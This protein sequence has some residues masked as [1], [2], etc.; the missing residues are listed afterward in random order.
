MATLLSFLFLLPAGPE[1][2]VVPPAPF[3]AARFREHV[4]YLASD[5][6]A[7]RDV[8]SA[9]NAKAVDYLVR[10]LK[11]CGAHGLAPGDE[12]VQAFP[13]ATVVKASMKTTLTA[14]GAPLRLGEDFAPAPQSPNGPWEGEM[15]FVGYAISAPDHGY[16]D[17]AGVDLKGKIAVALAETSKPLGAAGLYAHGQ[18]DRKW[19]ECESRGA[20]A[21]IVLSRPRSESGVLGAA[22]V[23][24]IPCLTVSRATMAR[25]LR[26]KEGDADPVAAAEEALAPVGKPKPGSRPLNRKV[27]GVVQLER[28]VTSGR[29]LIAVVPG[30]GELA[31]EAIVVSA[32]HDHLGTDPELIK[33]GKDGIY[34]GADD[35]ASGC[36]AMLLLAEALHSDRERLPASRRSVIFASFDA[37]ERGLM[38]SRYYVGHPLWPLERTTANLNFDMVGRLNKSKLGAMDSLSNPFLAERITALAAECGLGVETRLGGARRADNANFLDREIPAVHFN[39]GLHADYHQVTDEVSRID[40][41]GGARISWLAYRLLRETMARPGRLRYTAPPPQFDAERLIRLVFR[42][43]IVPELNT[44]KGQ[45]PLI[46]SVL[47]GSIAARNG[48][49]GGDE[50]TSINGTRIEGLQQA[51]IAF[52]QVRLQ[53]GLRVSVRRDGKTVDL[54][55]PAEAFKGFTGPEVR[56]LGGDQFEV[57]FRFQP[58]AKAASV[59]LAGTFND[60]SLK[61]QPMEGPD[62]QGFYTTKLRLKRG[63]YEYKFVVDGKT[64]VADP[65]NFS[66]IGTYGNSLLTLG[67][68]P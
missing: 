52:A 26:Q 65:S 28:T 7:G 18:L 21:L 45:Y 68:R 54:T 64:W 49:K 23:R 31:R 13:F 15:V 1:S 46:R 3:T 33:A 20:R 57:S 4:A 35:N 16:D 24:K 51:G 32:H 41:E 39:T 40:A 67:D 60:W 43:G 19:I 42:L 66:T 30:K 9:G 22:S 58:P 59:V 55:V 38:G 6:L 27:Q 62:K 12:W 29:N 10:H 63:S 37:E 25:L 47:P 56:P 8:A 34:N 2:T 14:D 48:L 53:D 11:E 44:Q 17:F 61:A 50:I 5:D 36:S